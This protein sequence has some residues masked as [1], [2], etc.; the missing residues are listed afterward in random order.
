VLK[1]VRM[2]NEYRSLA[3]FLQQDRIMDE[4]MRRLEDPEYDPKTVFIP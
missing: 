2:T 4:K 3:W 1:Q